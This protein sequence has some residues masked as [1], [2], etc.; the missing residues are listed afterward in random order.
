VQ[1]LELA[2]LIGPDEGSMHMQI[3]HSV[4]QPDGFV[5][6]HLHAFEESFYILS[7]E[8]WLRMLG[9]D[10]VLTTGDFGVV[11]LGVPHSWRNASDTPARWLRIRAPQ[12]RDVDDPAQGTYL[13]RGFDLPSE[14]TRP[15]FGLP[16][17]R[18]L[19]HFADDQMPPAGPVAIRG[20]NNY[21]VK[22]I[23]LRLM[24][25]DTVGAIHH[26]AFVGQMAAGKKVAADVPPPHYHAFEETYYFVGGTARGVLEGK[27]YDIVAGDVAFAGVNATH[28]FTPTSSEPLRWIEI[29]A[30]RPPSQDSMM[31]VNQW[32]ALADSAREGTF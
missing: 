12:P 26:V 30:P 23:S 1:G 17:V 18:H 19:G 8:V 15:A 16:S 27:E 24:V 9:R 20:T 4:L 7:G 13:C 32:Q 22:N 25:D 29:M 14:P 21:A 11:P 31:F 10:V 6:G 3:G 28:G 5:S 2:T